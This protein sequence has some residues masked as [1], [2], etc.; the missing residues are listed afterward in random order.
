MKSVSE[1]K[2]LFWLSL[3]SLSARKQAELIRLFGSARSLW[4]DFSS[5]TE[6][7][8]RIAGD[9]T[10]AALARF[11]SLDYLDMRLDGLGKDGIKVITALN[12]LFPK[13]LL[14]PEVNA[15][16]VL[17]YRG[18]INVFGSVCV[19]V[20]G[21]RAC[22]SYGREM[23]KT[24]SAE[25]AAGGV[26]VVSGLAAGIDSYAHAAAVDAGGKT[27]AVLGSGLNRV[28]PVSNLKLYDK[29]IE[30]GG[31]VVSEYKPDAV[32]AKFT[33]PERNRLI[34]GISRG[35]VVIEA[36]EK[37]G[38][39]ITARFAAEQNREVFALPGNVT[40]SRSAGCN[41]LLYDG[42][43]FIRNGMDV[44]E[45][46]SLKQVVQSE[47]RK[48]IVDKEQ[49]KLYSLLEDGIKSFDGLIESSGLSPAE[50]SEIL[51]EM[52]LNDLI[53]RDSANT[54]SIRYRGNT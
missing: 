37:S 2:I 1:S 46:L 50:L 45:Y 29:I 12:P 3:P 44:L 5:R 35:V 40:S 51:L 7:V 19:A 38:A 53:E 48:I 28:T 41:N 31:L 8:R 17:Y 54:F 27:I 47:K 13:L 9:D 32:A 49:K 4:D 15:P 22:T 42:A 14:Q 16:S 33:F 39:L 43:V 23:A 52:E 25:I 34:S 26:T 21:T 20:V 10:S 6:A 30:S 24:V 36:G 11:H 18:D